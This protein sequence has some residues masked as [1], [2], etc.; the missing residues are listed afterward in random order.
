MKLSNLFLR[1]KALFKD[2][3]IATVKNSFIKCD[4]SA[5]LIFCPDCGSD[6]SIACCGRDVCSRH[7]MS[8]KERKCELLSTEYFTCK[9]LL[10]RYF[11][12]QCYES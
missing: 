1:N 12:K 8:K 11:R 5:N 6:F 2:I 10:K 9:L 7:Y 4:K 3:E